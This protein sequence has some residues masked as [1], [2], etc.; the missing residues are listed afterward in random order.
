MKIIKL[1]ALCFSAAV[2]LSSCGEPETVPVDTENPFFELK[3]M[4]EIVFSDEVISVPARVKENY[5]T[6]FSSSSEYGRIVP[7][8]SYY[9]YFEGAKPKKGEAPTGFFPFYGFMTAEGKIICDA[10]Y[11]SV[12][13]FDNGDGRAVYE[14]CLGTDADTTSAGTRY[15]VSDTGSWVIKLARGCR[16]QNVSGGIVAVE[17]V[18]TVSKELSISY[19][20]LYNIDNGRSVGTVDPSIAE[21]PNVTYT[22]GSFSNGLAPINIETFDPES[23]TSS[24]KACYIDTQNRHVLDS[25]SYCGEFTDGFAVVADDEG[26]YGVMKPDGKFFIDPQYISITYDSLHKFF[27]CREEGYTSVLDMD[28]KLVKKIYTESGTVRICDSETLVYE[29]ISNTTD[30][31]EFF[32]LS[33]NSPF[34]CK[35]TGQMPDPGSG[36]GGY[37]W[38]SYNGSTTV[39]DSTGS[40]FVRMKGIGDIIFVTEN[41][42]VMTNDDGTKTAVINRNSPGDADWTEKS[43]IG[44]AGENGRYIILKYKQLEKDVYCVFDTVEMTAAIDGKNYIEAFGNMMSSVSDS[45]YEVYDGTMQK[46]FGCRTKFCY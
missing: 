41:A 10:V 15:L 5:V 35:D 17:R 40:T 7:F 24:Y 3:T 29:K 37:F 4:P 44:R 31:R 45:G 13:R 34:I 39:F 6:Y 26:K 42:I 18:K 16:L 20:D 30:K 14:M 21:S 19:I 43:L 28:K 11:N 46:V 1:L 23:K 32:I 27:I 9:G 38:C 12:T 2:F 36:A 33:D 22:L 25:Y 8:I